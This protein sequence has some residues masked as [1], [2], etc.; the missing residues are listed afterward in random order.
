VIREAI[1]AAVPASHM[2]RETAASTILAADPMDVPD[3]AELRKE[4]EELRSRRR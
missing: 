4:L 1:D 3:P 2:S